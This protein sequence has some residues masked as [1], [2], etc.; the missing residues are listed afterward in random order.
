M[1]S[2]NG[3]RAA[4]EAEAPIAEIDGLAVTFGRGS[5]A[6]EVVH[7]ASLVVRRGESVGL[8]G[9]SGSGKT[10]TALALMGLVP[11]VGGSV[12]GGRITFDGHDVTGL[13]QR[14]WTRLRGARIAMV[15]Q[16]PIRSL[17][18]AFSV[19]EQI[20]ESIRRHLGY[21]RKRAWARAVELLD[22]VRIPDAQRRARDYPHQFSGGMCQRVMIAMA[23]ACEPD[24]VIA[25]EP[26]TALDVTVQARILE[27][28]RAAISETGT[29]LL[30]IAHDLSVVAQMCQ[31]V[32]VMY[33]G[34]TVETGGIAD[35]FRH[36]LHP[37]TS[38]LLGCMPTVDTPTTRL[39]AIPG[40]VP[41]PHAMPAG[42]RFHPRCPYAE[43]G[44][45]DQPGFAPIAPTRE[46]VTQCVRRS[47][48]VLAG[49]R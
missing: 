7:S 9:E 17:D 44:R 46:H 16:Q 32:A 37:Y 31:R 33:A 49:M 47:E 29:S 39:T 12:T 18:P 40:V 8:V 36:P 42:C 19:G 5:R 11:L 14:E 13:T 10:T 23:L 2:S 48:L 25:D 28:L 26:T 34:E 4:P 27:L 6:V 30:Y 1:M 21:G 20:S 45:C 35:V 15:F 22:R 43:G 24:L 41:T 38:S 3:H